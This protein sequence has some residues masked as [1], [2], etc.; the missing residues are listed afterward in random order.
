LELS[1]NIHFGT[2]IN[3]QLILDIYWIYIGYILDISP[4]S[5]LTTTDSFPGSGGTR[6]S[7]SRK[8]RDTLD[9][10]QEPW[11]VGRQV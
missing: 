4:N 1:P 2:I 3:A 7:P 8:V 11:V 6:T 9:A 5:N 10:T